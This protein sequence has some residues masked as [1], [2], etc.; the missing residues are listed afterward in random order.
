MTT[1]FGTI[2]KTIDFEDEELT[3]IRLEGGGL[4]AVDASYLASDDGHVY[5]AFDANTIV[6]GEGL[7]HN[8]D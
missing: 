7:T 3:V 2:L 4:M 1:T 6:I 5:S 8:E